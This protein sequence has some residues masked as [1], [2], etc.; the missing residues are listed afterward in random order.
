MN[1]SLRSVFSF[2]AC[3]RLRDVGTGDSGDMEECV[4]FV[5]MWLE[6]E[7]FHFVMRNAVR[8]VETSGQGQRGQEIFGISRCD[9][10]TFA[11]FGPWGQREQSVLEQ[12]VLAA[13]GIPLDGRAHCTRQ[14][15]I[16]AQGCNEWPSPSMRLQDMGKCFVLG[17]SGRNELRPYIF[18]VK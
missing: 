1:G 4:D 10:I 16:Q 17:P 8:L 7:A 9:S 14:A 12:G 6:H 5:P 11:W 2:L 3:L 13:R 15:I 18:Q